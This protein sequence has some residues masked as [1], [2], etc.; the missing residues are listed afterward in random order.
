MISAVITAALLI[1]GSFFCLVA[2]VG[3][4]RLPDTLIRIHAA[5]K[6]GTLGAGFILM[7]EA[8]AI[9]ELGTTLRVAAIIVF[10]LLTAPVAAHLIGRAAYH[11]GI[12][13]FDKTW[14]DELGQAMENKKAA[15]DGGDSESREPE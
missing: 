10:L 11:R 7:A 4:L 5:T 14:I 15:S 3:M 12:H 8:V 13:L 2:A 1:V 6:A 9:A